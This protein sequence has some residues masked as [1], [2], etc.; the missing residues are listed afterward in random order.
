[1]SATAAA[2][3]TMAATAPAIHNR[4]GEE[5]RGAGAPRASDARAESASASAN[6]LIVGNRSAGCI[7]IARSTARSTCGEIVG[8]YTCSGCGACTNRCAITDSGVGPTN[9]ITPGVSS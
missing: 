8:R 3:T 1:M 7:A 5:G 4:L 9:G 6:A 2:A